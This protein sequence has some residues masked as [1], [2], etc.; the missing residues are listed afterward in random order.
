MIGYGENKEYTSWFGESKSG[1]KASGEIYRA[2]PV[3]AAV[4]SGACRQQDGRSSL[5]L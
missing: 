2:L 1:H 4:F 3:E 5:C